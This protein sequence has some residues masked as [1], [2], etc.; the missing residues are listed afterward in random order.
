MKLI[1]S[2]AIV[3]V[4]LVSTIV[5]ANQL[6]LKDMNPVVI[7]SSPIA[8]SESIAPS[9]SEITV[10]FSSDMMTNKMWSVVK[11]AN[12]QFPKVTGDVYFKDNQTF[13]MPVQL[14]P[15]TMY[16]FSINSK[17]KSGF[18]GVNGKAAQ[19]YTVYFKTSS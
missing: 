19:P 15:N 11:V 16:A 10:K 4:M 1:K 2:L 13:V 9:T 18:K 7:A 5:N 17:T 14:K 6:S 12:G 3:S 8:G